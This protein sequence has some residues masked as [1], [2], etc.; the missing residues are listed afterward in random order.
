MIAGLPDQPIRMAFSADDT[1]LVSAA[2]GQ[3]RTWDLTPQGPPALGNFHATGGFI[4]RFAMPAD[5]SAALVSVYGDNKAAVERI[6]ATGGA[7]SPVLADLQDTR[8]GDV[9]DRRRHVG[10]ERTRPVMAGARAGPRQRAVDPARPVRE[11][12]RPRRHRADRPDRRPDAVHPG[13][14]R[15][16]AASTAR[17]RPRRRHDNR[18]DPARPREQAIWGGTFGPIGA[19]GRPT[20]VVVQD[21]SAQNALHVYDLRTGT[22]IGAYTPPEGALLRVAVSPDAKRVLATT[23]TGRLVV[24][25]LARLSEA[26]NPDDAVAWSVKAHDGSVQALAVSAHG[27]IASGSSAGN[28]RV[29]SPDGRL[30]AD[31]TDPSR[32]RPEHRLRPRHRHPL[33]RGRQRRD[34]QVRSRRAHRGPARPLAR[35]PILHPR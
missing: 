23:T 10:G 1:R 3:L 25:D 21:A 5:G 19:D 14:R 29:W 32:R 18:A 27:L 15:R 13:A 6:D 11:R 24:L 12:R 20:L 17:R 33:L 9:V 30:L 31:L 34:P 4:G 2:P 22:E 8:P 16:A 35:H 28:V 7:I 26:S